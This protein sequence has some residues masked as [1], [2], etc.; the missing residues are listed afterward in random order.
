MGECYNLFVYREGEAA[1]IYMAAKM[2]SFDTVHAV[3]G[4]CARYITPLQGLERPFLLKQGTSD[5][6]TALRRGK[7]PEDDTQDKKRVEASRS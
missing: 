2:V 3:E 1:E 7:A 5:R 4:C 6:V